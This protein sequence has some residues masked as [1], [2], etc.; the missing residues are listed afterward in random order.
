MVSEGFIVVDDSS[1]RILEANPVA[2]TLLAGAGAT[3]GA[4]PFLLASVTR[5]ETPSIDSLGKRDQLLP[6][7]TE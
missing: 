6:L 1:G 4:N 3:L 5:Q 2:A 7:L